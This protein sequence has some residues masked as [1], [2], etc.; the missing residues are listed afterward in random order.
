MPFVNEIK[1]GLFFAS[2]ASLGL[3]FATLSNLA[4]GARE[5]MG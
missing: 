3:V 2:V 1:G 5:D 4:A